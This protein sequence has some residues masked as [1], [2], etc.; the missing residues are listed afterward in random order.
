MPKCLQGDV[1]EQPDQL[2]IVFGRKGFNTMGATWIAFAT[3]NGLPIDED[4]FRPDDIKPRAIG[5]DRFI[6]TVAERKNHGIGDRELRDV[7][8]RLI[9]WAHENGIR[10]IAT[11][12]IAD[13]NHGVGKEADRASDDRRAQMLIE[14]AKRYEDEFQVKITL[15]NMDEVFVRQKPASRRHASGNSATNRFS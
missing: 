3:R 7:F 14:L 1:L 2:L 4:P 15:A 11:N 8:D 10:T 6:A 5:S 13:V 12:G 9:R